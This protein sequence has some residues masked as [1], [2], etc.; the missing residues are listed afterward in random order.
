M[1]CFTVPLATAAA[2]SII[3]NTLPSNARRTTF[4]TKLGWLGKMMFGGSLLL[5][6]E[7]VYHAA[8][9]FS[10]GADST[11]LLCAAQDALGDRVLSVTASTKAFPSGELDAARQFCRARGVRHEVVSLKG[12]GR[13]FPD[14]TLFVQRRHP[15]NTFSRQ[16][17]HTNTAI[18]TFS[19]LIPQKVGRTA[20]HQLPSLALSPLKRQIARHFCRACERHPRKSEPRDVDLTRRP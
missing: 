10:G 16:A 11:L 14:E 7:H 19:R 17:S 9:A 12:N 8:V 3:K 2:A 1:A 15:I 4:A 5:A 20:F 13:A 18:Y 6:I